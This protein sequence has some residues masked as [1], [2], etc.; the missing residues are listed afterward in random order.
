MISPLEVRRSR[1]V[2]AEG[3]DEPC[4]SRGFEGAERPGV[5][6]RLMSAVRDIGARTRTSV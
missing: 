2:D 1:R 5:V 4:E 6:G 3:A